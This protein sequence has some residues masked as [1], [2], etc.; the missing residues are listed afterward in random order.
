MKKP[1]IWYNGE[2][3][4]LAGKVKPENVHD[5]HAKWDKADD[6]RMIC[7]TRGQTYLVEGREA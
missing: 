6:G 2:L 5:K 7:V 4:Q 3:V 1:M